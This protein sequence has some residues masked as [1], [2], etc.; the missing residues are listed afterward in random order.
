MTSQCALLRHRCCLFVLALTVGATTAARSQVEIGGPT[1][2][3]VSARDRDAPP[4]D[5]KLGPVFGWLFLNE[6]VMSETYGTVAIPGLMMVTD[7]SAD[8]R[9]VLGAGRGAARGN[10]FHDVTGYEGGDEAEL[11]TVPL[12]IGL[13]SD[14][15]PHPRLHLLC[16][17]SAELV[18]MRERLPAAAVAGSP[19]HVDFDGWGEGLRFGFGP[20][21]R[22]ADDRRVVGFTMEW[23]ASGGEVFGDG[24]RHEVN[25]TG[26]GL[27]FHVLWRL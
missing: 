17:L 21:W 2:P 8:T 11:T 24:R 7:V 23:S 12:R 26:T 1:P 20:E 10:P 14:L 25:L 5:V 9:F 13:Q 6:Q 3:P 15:S 4:L 16:G 27:Q 22:S 18:W 19:D